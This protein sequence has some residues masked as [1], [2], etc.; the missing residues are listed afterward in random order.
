MGVSSVSFMD[1]FLKGMLQNGQGKVSND[2]IKSWWNY[3]HFTKFA[4]KS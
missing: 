4:K 3:K 2:F 1:L